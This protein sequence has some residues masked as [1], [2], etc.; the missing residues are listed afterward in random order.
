MDAQR[1][2]LVKAI[3]YALDRLE[4]P[5]KLLPFL[6]QLARDHRKYG[7]EASH[8]DLAGRALFAAAHTYN[9]PAWTAELADGW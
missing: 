2:R 1:D 5:E 6:A 9:G 3:G 4:E 8:Y 7:V